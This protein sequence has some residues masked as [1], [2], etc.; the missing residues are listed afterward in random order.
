MLDTF[1]GANDGVP[2]AVP[3]SEGKPDRLVDTMEIFEQKDIPDYI[4]ALER[5][6]LN[7]PGTV[8][9]CGLKLR[10]ISSDDCRA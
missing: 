4:Q 7:N 10:R 2:F 5:P 8:A 1:I 9:H 6:D 3:G